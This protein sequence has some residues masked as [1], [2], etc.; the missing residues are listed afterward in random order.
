MLAEN[1]PDQRKTLACRKSLLV[2]NVLGRV[3]SFLVRNFLDEGKTLTC[4]NLP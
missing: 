4:G 3:K 1:V 2:E